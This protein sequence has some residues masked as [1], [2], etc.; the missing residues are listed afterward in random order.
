MALQR[1]ANASHCYSI[2]NHSVLVAQ[3]MFADIERREPEALSRELLLWNALL[4]AFAHSPNSKHG[5]HA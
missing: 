5:A 1:F 2:V 4:L 3:R